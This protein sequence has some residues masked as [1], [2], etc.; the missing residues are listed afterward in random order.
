MHR[1][2]IYFD[3]PLFEAIKQQAARLN[4]SV[5]AYI[6]KT[7]EQDIAAKKTAGQDKDLTEFAG[8]WK[9]R[10]ISQESLRK[11]AWK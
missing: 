3:E 10:D 7:L 11:Q 9:D 4:M 6:R 5:S 2:Q 8:M 1:T